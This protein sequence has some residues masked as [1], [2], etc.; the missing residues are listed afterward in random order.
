MRIKKI[1]TWEC[2][3]GE[4]YDVELLSRNIDFYSSGHCMDNI[5][6]VRFDNGWESSLP[7]WTVE[8]LEATLEENAI[9]ES[10]TK[11]VWGK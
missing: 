3:C 1:S 6:R 4:E 5:I 9:L 11:R 7:I 10:P 8:V 2:D